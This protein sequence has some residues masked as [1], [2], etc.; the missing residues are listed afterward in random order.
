MIIPPVIGNLDM[1]QSFVYYRDTLRWRVY[2]VDSPHD[3]KSEFPGKKPSVYAWWTYQPAQTNIEK[4]F[5]AN[6]DCCNIGVAPGSRL[7]FIDLDDKTNQGEG[8]RRW[9]AEHPELASIPRHDTHNGAHFVLHCVDLPKWKKE[10]GRPHYE[11]LLNEQLAESTTAGLYHSDHSNIIVPPSVHPNGGTYRWSVFGRIPEVSWAWLQKTFGFTAPEEAHESRKRKVKKGAWFERYEDD[12]RS[13]DLLKLLE[14]LGV[15]TE[16]LNADEKKHAVPC[17]WRAEHTGGNADQLSSATVV[18]LPENKFPVFKCL[19]D[20]CNDRSLEH[21]LDWAEGKIPGIVD[22]FCCRERVWHEGQTAADNRPRVVRTGK[23]DTAVHKE[24]GDIIARKDLWFRYGTRLVAVRKVASG[25]LYSAHPEEKYTRSAYIEGIAELSATDV[26]NEIEKHV[27]PGVLVKDSNGQAMFTPDSFPLEFCQRL[28]VSEVF[29][30]RL[31]ELHKVLTVPIPFLWEGKIAEPRAGYDA[32]FKTYLPHGA[33]KVTPMRLSEARKLLRKDLF[34][35][36]CFTNEQSRIHAIARLLT[37]FSRALLPAWTTI[38]PFWMLWANRPRAGKDYLAAIPSI[39]LHGFPSEGQPPGKDS[40]ETAKRI[41]AANLAGVQLMHFANVQRFLQD[42]MLIQAV[43]GPYLTARQ[44]GSNAAAA[45][46][47]VPNQAIYSVSLNIGTQCSEDFLERA[48]VIE[49]AFFD[50]NANGRT[51]PKPNLHGWV[52]ANR[53]RIISAVFAIFR[54]WEKKGFPQ[55]KPF[56]SFPDWASQVGGVMLAAALGDPCQPY[57]GTYAGTSR[58]RRT[59]AMAELFRVCFEAFPKDKSG[60]NRTVW[61]NKQQIYDVLHDAAFPADDSAEEANEA[62]QFFGELKK[63]GDPV[64]DKDVK[65]CQTKLGITLSAFKN[66]VLGGIRLEL[67]DSSSKSQRRRFRFIADHSSGGSIAPSPGSKS[68]HLAT[69]VASA[70]ELRVA[71]SENTLQESVKS[72]GDGVFSEMAGAPDL[73]VVSKVSRCPPSTLALEDPPADLSS[74]T[75]AVDIETYAE[76]RT[77]KNGKILRSGDALNPKKGEIRLLS[78]ADP[79]GGISLRDLRQ[80][81][82]SSEER[83]ILQSRELIIHN[84]SFELRFLGAKLGI[85]PQRVFCT[86]HGGLA[87][88]PAQGA[89][90]RPEKLPLQAS[91]NRD[92]ERAGCK[93]LGRFCPHRGADCIRQE[94]RAISPPTQRPA[95]GGPRRHEAQRRL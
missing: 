52:A 14:K 50:E 49:L 24:L 74:P 26:A 92:S 28:A 71:K 39:L 84:G 34:G 41:M 60:D 48:R 57:I 9:L 65:S 86:S 7:A 70:K 83:E 36:F 88:L 20:H 89:H 2:P 87:S 81:P 27:E 93:R 12:L 1:R 29:L 47:T 69:L 80:T 51:F 64:T 17:P 23:L 21:L 85:I 63:T 90:S 79:S 46:L 15:E 78:I 30:A 44:L 94:R 58:D 33:P 22:D 91:P 8:V 53:D 82:L 54:H 32:R 59:E 77:G 25:F 16:L 13:L 19:H 11:P 40:A 43:T 67:D 62:L 76:V 31:P 95:G 45:H 68:G 42:D 3:K 10:S 75:L 4:K 18:F 35:G 56:T 55:G 66:R 5:P 37:V 61:V 72:V 6:G 73:I 38:T